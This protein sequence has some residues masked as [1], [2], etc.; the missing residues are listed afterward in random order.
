MAN[1]RPQPLTKERETALRAWVSEFW[2]DR[3]VLI[4]EDD[5]PK[6]I[7]ISV[8]EDIAGCLASLDAA[9]D[10]VKVERAA[11]CQ[12]ADA[13]MDLVEVGRWLAQ[14]QPAA[15][16]KDQAEAD[17]WAKFYRLL[18]S[19]PVSFQADLD[20]AVEHAQRSPDE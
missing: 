5:D 7:G 3:F 1:E 14:R 4:E 17:A 9:L 20:A 15:H 2:P 19:A 11:K 10:A 16:A 13:L 18:N 6:K 12:F 8:G